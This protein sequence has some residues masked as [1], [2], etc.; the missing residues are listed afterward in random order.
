MNKKFGFTLIELLGVIILL[1][2][3][4]LITYPIIDKSINDWLI[5]ERYESDT[6]DISPLLNMSGND[7]VKL[8]RYELANYYYK[9]NNQNAVK[10]AKELKVNNTTLK[11]WLNK[12]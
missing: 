10:A 4:A 1:A 11:N 9:K 2:V 5:Y 7:A 12:K 8:V 3:I 6:F